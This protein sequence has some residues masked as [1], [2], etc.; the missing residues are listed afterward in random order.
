MLN[1]EAKLPGDAPYIVCPQSQAILIVCH[2]MANMIVQ[3]EG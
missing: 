2:D 1:N 3:G